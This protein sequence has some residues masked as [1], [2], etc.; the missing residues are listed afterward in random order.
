[1]RSPRLRLSEDHIKGTSITLWACTPALAAPG[2]AM[3]RDGG[4]PHFPYRRVKGGSWEI[5]LGRLVNC[6]HHP[7]AARRLSPQT[8]LHTPVPGV[9]S[10]AVRPP[11]NTVHI[12]DIRSQGQ[13][14]P[15]LANHRI[16][17]QIRHRQRLPCPH[18]LRD[19]RPAATSRLLVAHGV[20]SGMEQIQPPR[21]RKGRYQDESAC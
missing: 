7:S 19:A 1:M 18:F 11:E 21:R 20:S 17:G 15:V 16:L 10:K 8:G 9:S 5:G 4:R 2:T 13:P 14:A 3:T 6:R 12:S